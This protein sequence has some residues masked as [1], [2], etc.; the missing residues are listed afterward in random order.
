MNSRQ[1]RSRLVAELE[2][3]GALTNVA[4]RQA[5]LTV[6]REAFV[7]EIRAVEGLE[8]VYRDD[9]IVT[10]YAGD[11]PTSSS[12]Q[13]TIMAR[14]LE[15]LDVAAGQRVLEIGLGTG[16]NAALLKTLVGPAG[17]VVSVDNNP[18]C[19]RDATAHL[20]GFGVETVLGN[21][22]DGVLAAAPFDR[23][24]VTASAEECPRSWWEQLVPGGL[25]V[26][27]IRMTE[28]LDFQAVAVLAKT[29]DGFDS[30][31]VIPGGFM[32]LRHDGDPLYTVPPVITAADGTA[33]ATQTLIRLGGPGVRRRSAAGQGRLQALALATPPRTKVMRGITYGALIY[34]RL[35]IPDDQLVVLSQRSGEFGVGLTNQRGDSLAALHTTWGTAPRARLDSW[36]DPAPAGRL[37]DHLT[38]WRRR[39][40]PG[41]D[42]L[43]IAIRY[44]RATRLALAAP[45]KQI[46]LPEHTIHVGWQT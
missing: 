32:P 38:A 6:A 36:G 4:V 35:A 44:R 8:R 22:Y 24:V 20:E 28:L 21:G 25:L 45:A 1:L 18:D 19:V 42:R 26:V 33:G 46:R 15:A 13:P 27:P 39:G 3:S 14:M 10:R 9:P 43:A 41:I 2:A 37:T 11:V 23:I 7:P 16:Y 12:S 34:L 5:F 29:R 31:Q 40:Q 30:I 17:H